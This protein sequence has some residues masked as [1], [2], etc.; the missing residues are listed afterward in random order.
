MSALRLVRADEPHEARENVVLRRTLERLTYGT[1]DRQRGFALLPSE[2]Q[3]LYGALAHRTFS[4]E[5]LDQIEAAIRRMDPHELDTDWDDHRLESFVAAMRSRLNRPEW[6]D[7]PI[8][9]LHSAMRDQGSD[10]RFRLWYVRAA[11]AVFLAVDFLP[12]LAEH[13]RLAG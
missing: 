13:S 6:I 1:H 3:A 8:H 12:D 10:A 11:L 5:Q 7:L 9:R 2:A 4:L